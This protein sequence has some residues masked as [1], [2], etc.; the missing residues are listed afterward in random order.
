MGNN[1]EGGDYFFNGG[2]DE[3]YIYNRALNVNEIQTLMSGPAPITPGFTVIESEG[4]TQVSESGT[5]DTF[6]VVLDTQPDS[7]VVLHVT[8]S[9]PGE[10][11]VDLSS[12]TFTPTNWDTP[13]TVTVT[14]QDDD[15]IDGEQAVVI[16]LSIDA[17]ESDDQF[18][19]VLDQTV[20][21]TT[22]DDDTPAGFTVIESE[23]S[24]QVS[25]S[26]TSDTFQVVLDT[27]PDSNV[28]LNVTVSDASEATVNVASL[29]FTAA[30]WDAPQTVV[31]TGQDDDVD[32]G[33]QTTMVTVSVD[34]AQSDDTFDSVAD[35]LVHVTTTDDDTMTDEGLIAYWP[36][37]EASGSTTQDATG[38]GYT[39]TLSGDVSFT[40]GVVHNG[41]EFGGT[42]GIITFDEIDYQMTDSL[43]IAFWTR[44]SGTDSSYQAILQKDQYC[45]PFMIWRYGSVL[46]V[47]V[48]TQESV[49]YLRSSSTLQTDAWYHVA[50]TC[51][52]GVLSLYI[53]GVLDNQLAVSG[54]LV[55]RSASTTMGN[56]AEGGDYFFN[57][58]LDEVY[59]Y[60]RAL[61]VNEIQTLAAS[62]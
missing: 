40:T 21:V 15:L 30:N 25:E 48:R 20:H 1:A 11:T 53:D 56:N 7:D 12:L 18:D 57:G 44:F 60:N 4:S 14:G 31:V 35:H 37:D 22:M 28:V 52:E 51:Q 39:G 62:P 17:V 9:D 6:Q 61:N 32:D 10:A 58:G 49:Y 13:Q 33:D 27:Q 54:S 3:V 59:I 19:G 45:R 36:L 38:H 34:E 24:T 55:E 47:A 16:T 26:G 41:V 8:T 2:L 42:D 23:G 43:T 5:S 50:A 29:V 46:R